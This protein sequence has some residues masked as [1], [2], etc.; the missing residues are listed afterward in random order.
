MKYKYQTICSMESQ[1][2]QHC[3]KGVRIDNW[4]SF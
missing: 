2:F 1:V 3:H 4:N